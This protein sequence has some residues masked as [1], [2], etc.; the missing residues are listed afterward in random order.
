MPKEAPGS[1]RDPTAG[2]LHSSRVGSLMGTISPRLHGVSPD[3]VWAVGRAL[4]A[5]YEKGYNEGVALGQLAS[6]MRET[7]LTSLGRVNK[8]WYS[9]PLIPKLGGATLGLDLDP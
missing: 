5:Y 6:G 7:V 8:G 4:E 9:K 1:A 2:D 3:E